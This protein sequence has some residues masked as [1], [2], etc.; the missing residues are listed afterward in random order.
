MTITVSSPDPVIIAAGV[1][2]LLLATLHLLFLPGLILRQE[3]P[4]TVAYTIGLGS[5]L[6]TFSALYLWGRSDP[7]ANLIVIRDAW[8]IAAAAALPTVG[9]R[10]VRDHAKLRDQERLQNDYRAD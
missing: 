10:F 5:F 7:T 9:L 6:L 4:R 8:I 2:V 1:Q 3:L